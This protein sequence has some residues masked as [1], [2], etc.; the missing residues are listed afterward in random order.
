MEGG[1][2]LGGVEEIVDDGVNTVGVLVDH[3]A[4]AVEA[5]FDAGAVGDFQSFAQDSEDSVFQ[6]RLVGRISEAGQGADVPKH[7]ARVVQR[8]RAGL[9]EMRKGLGAPGGETVFVEMV[10]GADALE[11]LLKGGVTVAQG[12]EVLGARRGSEVPNPLVHLCVAEAG[13]IGAG[14]GKGEAQELGVVGV[15]AVKGRVDVAEMPLWR[16]D[17]VR[18]NMGQPLIVSRMHFVRNR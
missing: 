8:R 10:N 12:E 18:K 6:G 3:F 13:E 4:E 16:G 9:V 17:V 2:E 1:V 7:V 14:A 15:G 11:L 5:A